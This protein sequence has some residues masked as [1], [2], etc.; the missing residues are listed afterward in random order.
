M[1]EDDGDCTNA[2]CDTDHVCVCHSGYY[3]NN[4]NATLC[5]TVSCKLQVDH[6]NLVPDKT[7]YIGNDEVTVTCHA[8]YLVKD[9]LGI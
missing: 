2:S 4:G 9:D 3:E 7:S 6:A 8:H 1:C 5:E